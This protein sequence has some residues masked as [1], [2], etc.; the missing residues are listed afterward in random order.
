MFFLPPIG[1]FT[2]NGNIVYNGVN[3]VIRWIRI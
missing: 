1:Y 3:E 2:N